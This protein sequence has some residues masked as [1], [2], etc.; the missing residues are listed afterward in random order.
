M[1]YLA[2]V[3]VWLALVY[4]EHLHH[5]AAWAWLESALGPASPNSELTFC[6]VTE[7]GFLRL[8]SN[9]GVMGKDV[10]TPQLAW[11][12]LVAYYQD[13]RIQFAPEP[14]GLRKAWQTFSRQH[15]HGVNFWT[16]A[17]LAAFAE[18]KGATLV[19]FDRDFRGYSGLA[20]KLL[21]TK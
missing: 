4:D 9:P 2:D 15:K 7:M 18:I 12:A 14:A 17:Y 1:T 3:N 20:V 21:S 5:Q 16:N 13:P 6:R 19:T 8:L 10:R 11:D